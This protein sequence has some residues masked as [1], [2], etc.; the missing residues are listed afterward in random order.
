MGLLDS[1]RRLFSG[2]SSMRDRY[3]DRQSGHD[4]IAPMDPTPSGTTGPS[5]SAIDKSQGE[6][7][8]IEPD[9]PK[10]LG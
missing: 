1:L 3:A 6:H 10:D 7:G 9:P 5:G 2:G 4:P 8:A